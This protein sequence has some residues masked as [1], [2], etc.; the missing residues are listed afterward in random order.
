MKNSADNK[1][2]ELIGV[3]IGDG[4]LWSNRA[5]WRIEVTG[6]KLKDKC[7]FFNYLKPMFK[8][9]TNNKIKFRERQRALR[10]RIC[11]KNLFYMLTDLGLNQR[12]EKLRN[13]NFL[14]K[15]SLDKKI[16]VIRGLVDTD[17]SVYK[18]KGGKI[19]IQIATSSKFL[20]YWIKLTLE[21][22][23]FKPYINKCTDKRPN[24]K[25]I[26]RVYVY[27]KL[28]L[29]KWL[30]IIGFSNEY[31]LIKALKIL[32]NGTVEGQ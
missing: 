6:D 9:Y 10:L 3:L 24:R 7:Y 21:K 16:L 15:L 17:G 13:L 29:E 20:A 11:S 12:K 1:I 30:K 8:K 4:N 18:T 22:L 14:E 28:G 25:I 27:D 31:K 19:C 26:F 32:S 2:W 23:N 5:H